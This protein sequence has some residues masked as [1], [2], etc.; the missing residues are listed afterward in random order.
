MK[1]LFPGGVHYR[2]GGYRACSNPRGESAGYLVHLSRE[3]DDAPW[4]A[5]LARTPGGHY[6]QT[7]MWGQ[8]KSFLGWKSIRLM[9]TLGGHIVAGAQLLIRRIGLFGPIAVVS[10]GP[11]FASGDPDLRRLVFEE[12]NRTA[13]AQ[14]ARCLVLQPPEDCES[15]ARLLAR[16]GFAPLSIELAPTATIL[17]DLSKGLGEIE[18]AMKKKTRRYIRRGLRHGITCREG[19]EGDLDH[20]YRMLQATSQRQKWSIYSKGYFAQVMRVFGRND[21]AKLFLAEYQG[22]VVSA[23]LLIGFGDTVTAKNFGW[24]GLHGSLGPN[25]VLEW[26]CIEWAKARGYRYYDL[27]GIHP[28][29]AAAV[30]QGQSVGG[31]AKHAWCHYKLQYGGQVVLYPKAQLCCYNPVAHWASTRVLGVMENRPIVE[32]LLN[33]IRLR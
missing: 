26:N 33:L 25:H 29:T 32:N 17:L 20:F 8:V 2:S 16:R 19:G 22:E 14:G 13:K 27:E 31:Q 28:E 3:P 21:H 15:L 5:F 6:V 9:V 10:K 30:L 18:A 7:S 23:Q 24:S 1:T 12:L 11:V 4:D